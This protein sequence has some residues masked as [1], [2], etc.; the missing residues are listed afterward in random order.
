[1]GLYDPIDGVTNLKY[2]LMCFLTTIFFYKEK[3]ALGFKWDRCCHLVLCLWLI[4]LYFQRKMVIRSFMD[5]QLYPL[6]LKKNKTFSPK[7]TKGFNC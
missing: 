5:T 2:V 7:I 3:K 6:S 1:M 4:L